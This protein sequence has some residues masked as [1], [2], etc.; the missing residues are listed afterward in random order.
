M[1]DIIRFLD[2]GKDYN[3]DVEDIYQIADPFNHDSITFSMFILAAATIKLE[4]NTDNI[5]LIQFA[6]QLDKE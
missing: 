5:S 6:N 3:I 4:F 1:Q 2:P